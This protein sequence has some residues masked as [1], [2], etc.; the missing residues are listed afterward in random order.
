MCGAITEWV[1]EFTDGSSVALDAAGYSAD[2]RRTTEILASSRPARPTREELGIDLRI[3]LPEPSA[4]RGGDAGIKP[5]TTLVRQI[6]SRT[7]FLSWKHNDHRCRDESS[8]SEPSP[9][10]LTRE[11]GLE[12]PLPMPLAPPAIPLLRRKYPPISRFEG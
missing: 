8:E 9:S 10:A 4:G 6:H 7:V 1:L 3:E 12:L 11:R 2:S 5:L